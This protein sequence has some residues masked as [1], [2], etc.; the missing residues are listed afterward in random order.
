MLARLI[1]RSMSK[2]PS[3]ED[4]RDI[5]AC[6]RRN[7]AQRGIT[8]A[9]CH[10]RGTY[11]QYLEGDEAAIRRLMETIGQDPRHVDLIVL[12]YRFI[13]ARAFPSWSMALIDWNADV[14]E[15]LGPLS[16]MGLCGIQPSMAAPMFRALSQASS[17]KTQ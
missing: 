8:G 5:L 4:L 14:Q 17:W 2:A 7:N 16:D 10:L 6:S 13:A 11:M 12:E 9:L 15:V 1:Y 3:G